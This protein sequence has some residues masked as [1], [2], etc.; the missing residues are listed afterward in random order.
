MYLARLRKPFGSSTDGISASPD[1]VLTKSQLLL[2]TNYLPM[3]LSDDAII[4]LVALLVMCVPAVSFGA[5]L[6]QKRIRTL[7]AFRSENEDPGKSRCF[8]FTLG[9]S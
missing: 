7:K 3:S 8:T 5:R 6:I 4:G 1:L 9:S 2:T